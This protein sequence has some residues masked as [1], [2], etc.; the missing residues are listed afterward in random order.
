MSQ[1]TSR[2]QSHATSG[3]NGGVPRLEQG[4][5]DAGLTG[6]RRWDEIGYRGPQVCK[7]VGISYRQLDYWARTDLVR[8]SLADA[9][10]SGTQRRYSY[11]DL[12]RSR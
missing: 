3:A 1:R 12:V 9:Q 2:G 6:R 11:R 7:I 4:S 10:G 8:P 5:L